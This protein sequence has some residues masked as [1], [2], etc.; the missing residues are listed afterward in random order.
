M[1]KMVYN[2]R[3]DGRKM[4]EPRPMEAKA[5]I[6]KRADGSAMFK[7][8]NTTALAA[9]Y[10]PR[11]LYPRF[12][13]DP[14][15]GILRVNYNMLPFSGHGDRVRPGGN[16]RSKELSLVIE[17]ALLPV[18]NLEDFP[19]SVIDI[20]I[21]FPE[22]DA[23]TRCAGICAASM[24]LADAGI[25]M[26]DLV[27]S[28]AIGRVHNSVLVDL[29]YDEEAYEPPVA[30]MPVAMVHRTKEISLLQM[31][32]EITEEQVREGLELAKKACDKAYE[33]QVKALK[34]RYN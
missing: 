6:I 29:N 24:A 33:V 5:G 34:A 20:F 2:K 15:K 13:Q 18:L 9:V 16:R 8:G 21:E 4:D 26:K 22:T 3:V 28:V 23:G 19:N 31:D 14:K 25:A 11:S 12:K 1:K 30:D 27:S 10:G 32:G 7:S 17:K